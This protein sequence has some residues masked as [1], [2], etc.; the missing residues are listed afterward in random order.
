MRTGLFSR[1]QAGMYSGAC[2]TRL[3][4]EGGEMN[5]PGHCLPR[6]LLPSC[7]SAAERCSFLSLGSGRREKSFP[8]QPERW[9]GSLRQD[10]GED[11]GI[12]R[13]FSKG[14]GI[15]A[16][17]EEGAGEARLSFGWFL[18]FAH[19]RVILYPPQPGAPSCPLSLFLPRA[20]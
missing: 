20:L 8:K 5:P 3:V 4:L 12:T 14:F 10:P 16:R 13:A 19:L 6:D 18:P 11:K 7:V 1:A 15:G 9:L 17:G 2:L